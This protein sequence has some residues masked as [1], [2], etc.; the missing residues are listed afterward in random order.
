M[1]FLF[2]IFLTLTL[3]SSAQD[4]NHFFGLQKTVSYQ[5]LYLHT[6]REFYFIGDTLWFAAYLLDGKTQIPINENCNI[7]VDLIN[8]TGE[9]VQKEFFPMK[10]GYCPG[11]IPFYNNNLKEGNYLIR[12]YNDYLKNFEEE[13]FFTKTIKISKVKNTF[14]FSEMPGL[15]TE[16][17]KINIDFFPEGGF[18]LADK[19][20]HVAFKATDNLGNEIEIKGKL[21]NNEGKK[22]AEFGTIYKGM[23]RFY[24]S[25]KK[26]ENYKIE[27]EGN[28]NVTAIFPEIRTE[29]A[30]IM[31]ASSN[32]DYVDLNI[33]ASHK[34]RNN[35]FYIAGIY[36]GE[37]IFYSKID[38]AQIQKTI[39][40]KTELFKNGIN[41]LV[42]L[43]RNFE[44]I[45]ERMIFF[46]NKEDIKLEI[47]LGDNEF[48]TREI[49]E[50]FID[51]SEFIPQNKY[52]QLSVAV[53]NENALNSEGIIQNIK[54]FLLIDSELNG[55]VSSP[56]QY[57]IDDNKLSSKAKLN[58]L[59]LTNGWKNYMWNKLKTDSVSV[60]IENVL[61]VNFKGNIKNTS[62]KKILNNSDISLGVFTDQASQLL[63][64]NSDFN[65]N[66][67]FKNVQFYDTAFIFLQGKNSKNKTNTHLDL[68]QSWL[69]FPEI[70][71][72]T[73]LQLNQFNDIPVSLYRLKYINEIALKEFYPDR[74]SKMLKEIN[75]VGN[76]PEE[77]GEHFRVYSTPDYSIQ[78]K[79]T[80]YSY[81]SVFSFLAGRVPG[82]Q[83]NGTQIIIRGPS[84]IMGNNEPL[85]LLD[86]IK[87]NKGMIESMSM[88]NIDKIEVLKG[89]STAMFGMQ[90]GNG[91]I[92]V[93]TKKGAVYEANPSAIP[94]TIVQKIMGFARY[95]EIYL[96]KYNSN[97]QNSKA[98]DFRT[99]LYWNPDIRLE[100]GK[101]DFSFFTCDNVSRYKIF[102]EGITES[103]RI[104]LGAAEFE[105]N[106]KHTE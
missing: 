36:R 83:V 32:T 3:T 79:S 96:P 103:G 65:G 55:S 64:S 80:D 6:D 38:E 8:E 61:G 59:M 98:P 77:K 12:A 85:F 66:F 97:N 16:T 93:F 40:L 74:D 46:D 101:A 87:V 27:I 68:D 88:F 105:V 23:G 89:A 43:N 76:K 78:L 58:L 21:I 73:I 84:S 52:T 35:T 2:F 30:K 9:I 42:L 99:T 13:S 37:G 67:E 56:N 63:F 81:S 102:V 28:K 70:S 10:N 91:V 19:I 82:V 48:S 50:V 31:V 86:G 33:I 49:V 22:I 60:K 47:D 95:R 20:N 5:K 106:K 94:G 1:N 100:N 69:K 11:Y 4:I 53:V 44:P 17:P 71:D 92:S 15:I 41:R 72:K 26:N 34:N 54:S 7:H 57:F 75:V 45:S 18:I 25:P 29:G 90:G 14:G 51:G 39:R 24:F 104:C 62:Q